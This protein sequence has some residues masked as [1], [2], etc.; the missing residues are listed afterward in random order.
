MEKV[1]G[2]WLSALSKAST[3]RSDKQSSSGK[4]NWRG[5]EVT[6]VFPRSFDF[7]MP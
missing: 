7:T 4:E 2:C 1:E 6:A 5:V 3:S